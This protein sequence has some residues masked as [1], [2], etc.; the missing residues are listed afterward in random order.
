MPKINGPELCPHGEAS[1]PLGFIPCR[2][3]T[4]RDAEPTLL[5]GWFGCLVPQDKRQ[6]VSSFIARICPLPWV[7]AA[8][9]A[10]GEQ[11]GRQEQAHRLPCPQRGFSKPCQWGPPHHPYTFLCKQ[12]ELKTK[13]HKSFLVV[14][15]TSALGEL[16]QLSSDPPG[17]V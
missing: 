14:C 4:C 16:A 1:Q 12:G 3:R 6:T 17:Q 9:P 2:R 8:N 11:P 7:R 5:P 13:K 10:G 15:E